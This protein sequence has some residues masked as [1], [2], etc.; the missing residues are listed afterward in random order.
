MRKL[1]AALLDG[2]LSFAVSVTMVLTFGDDDD[3]WDRQDLAGAAAVSA[4][5]SAVCAGRFGGRRRWDTLRNA[6]TRGA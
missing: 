6:L 4:F 1:T 5:L 2:A 3:P